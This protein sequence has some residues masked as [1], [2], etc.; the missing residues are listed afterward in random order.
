L[1]RAQ[2]RAELWQAFADAGVV[3]RDAPLPPWSEPAVDAA[4]AFV[5]RS[6]SPLA[7]VPMED[8]LGET[9]QPNLPG[10]IDEHPNWRRRSR[11]PAA[12]MLDAVEVRSRLKTL[13]ER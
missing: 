6:S 5:A 10:T 3:A 11:R 12:E 13:R 4:I 7:L 9:E 8:I 1:Q 2:D